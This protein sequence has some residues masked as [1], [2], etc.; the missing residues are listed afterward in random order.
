M[1]CKVYDGVDYGKKGADFTIALPRFK[2][3]GKPDEL[4]KRLTDA[5]RP[6]RHELEA[7]L[8]YIPQFKS[9]TWIESVDAAPPF[10]HF[11]VNTL[12]LNRQVLSQIDRLTYHTSSGKPEY[13]RN[14][15]GK[16][17]KVIIGQILIDP[18][19]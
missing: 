16:G 10:L 15:D 12:T 6:S 2:L 1:C 19:T 4:A 17:K 8:Q 7:C 14:E 13:G 11:Q 3:K 5:V 9:D 18:N